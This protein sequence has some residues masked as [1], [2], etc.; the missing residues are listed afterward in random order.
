MLNF[1]F[2]AFGI[3]VHVGILFSSIDQRKR[4]TRKHLREIYLGVFLV[5][6]L[7]CSYN[8]SCIEKHTQKKNNSLISMERGIMSYNE[9]NFTRKEVKD[10]YKFLRDIFNE[11]CRDLSKE[12]IAEMRK[13]LQNLL[14]FLPNEPEPTMAECSWDDKK[15]YLAEA[16]VLGPGDRLDHPE[17]A[18][19]AM[20]KETVDR[21]KIVAINSDMSD[22][23][24]SDY[25]KEAL[26]PTGRY[27]RLFP[28]DEY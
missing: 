13:D 24:V 20:L 22:T 4:T 16:E 25:T 28:D 12:E 11:A 21:E 23:R 3:I 2:L 5:L 27:Y 1:V 7:I 8:G 14:R 18:I 9:Q 10:A 26:V 6:E 19:V 15:H 17:Y